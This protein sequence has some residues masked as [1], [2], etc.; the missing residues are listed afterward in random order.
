MEIG[1]GVALFGEQRLA[2]A[3]PVFA[4]E[5]GQFQFDAVAGQQALDVAKGFQVGVALLVLFQQWA[6]AVLQLFGEL[7]A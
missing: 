7:V 3:A 2:G 5:A 4:G 1:Q 6:G